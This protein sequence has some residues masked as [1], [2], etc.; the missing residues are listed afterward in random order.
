[1]NAQDI[2]A[3]MLATLKQ[4]G[5]PF[6]DIKVFGAIRCNVH[7]TCTSQAAARRWQTLLNTV[8]PGASARAVQ[9]QWNAAANHGTCLR[10]TMRKGWLV[11]IAA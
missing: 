6:I 1:M 11:G 8:F 3:A 5:I 7:I 9:T 2:Q 4:A 10:P